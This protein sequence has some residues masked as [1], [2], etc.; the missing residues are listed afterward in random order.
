MIKTEK[1]ATE[2]FALTAE[3]V[4]FDTQNVITAFIK[5]SKETQVPEK[6]IE[7]TLVKMIANGFN[8]GGKLIDL[9][10]YFGEEEDRE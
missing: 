4:A 2:I 5:F 10:G 8:K 7:E 1:G 3:E 6:V 9:S